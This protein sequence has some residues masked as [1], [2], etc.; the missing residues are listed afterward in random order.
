MVLLCLPCVARSSYASWDHHYARGARAECKLLVAK[1]FVLRAGDVA[2]A[3]H[4]RYC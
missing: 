1:Q 4:H 2:R 3:E